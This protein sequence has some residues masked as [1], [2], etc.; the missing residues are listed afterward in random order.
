[1]HATTARCYEYKVVLRAVRA[2]QVFRNGHNRRLDLAGGGSLMLCLARDLPCQKARDGGIA[3]FFRGK[4]STYWDGALALSMSLHLC[5]PCSGC[6]DKRGYIYARSWRQTFALATERKIIIGRWNG[7]DAWSVHGCS[8]ASLCLLRAESPQWGRVGQ[9]DRRGTR[10]RRQ[11]WTSPD[12]RQKGTK[13]KGKRQKAKAKGTEGLRGN[14]TM[15]WTNVS[16]SQADPFLRPRV[17][18]VKS[19]FKSK[20][21]F[22]PRQWATRFEERQHAERLIYIAIPKAWWC[23]DTHIYTHTHTHSHTLPQNLLT[24]GS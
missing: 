22:H 1:M 17:M 11:L 5:K 19:C 23:R 13:P 15:I 16:I 6:H 21:P 20:V 3:S 24:L 4:T 18:Q 2:G 14:A 7:D 9:Q 10:K 8:L 12:A